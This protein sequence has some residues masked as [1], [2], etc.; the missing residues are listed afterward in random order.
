MALK[1]KLMTLEDFKAVRDVDVASNSAQ[2]TEIKADL[3]VIN[4]VKDYYINTSTTPINLTPVLSSAGRKYAVID[5]SP[6]D[7]FVIN[8]YSDWGDVRAWCFIDNSNNAVSMADAQVDVTGLELTAPNNA[9]KLIINDMRGGMS[10]KV[11][12]NL[13]TK[14]SNGLSDEVK[15]AILDCFRNVAWLDKTD[16]KESFN[17]L[18]EAFGTSD[19]YNTWEWTCPS[20]LT[21]MKKAGGNPNDN[22]IPTRITIND[23]EQ[24]RTITCKRGKAPYYYNG[25]RSEYYPVPIPSAAKKFRISSSLSGTFAYVHTIRFNGESYGDSITENRVTWTQLPIEKTL[26]NT[27][28]LFMIVNLKYTSSGT[29]FPSEP[30]VAITFLEE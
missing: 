24:R 4:L 15:E 5:C 3:G 6:G 1:D 25:V 18:L 9:A 26:E 17:A 21:I 22:N 10:Y 2:F 8:A 16:G 28:N 11:G 29:N 12:N 30:N 14:A 27:G 23:S 20:S 7:K 13:A 19:F